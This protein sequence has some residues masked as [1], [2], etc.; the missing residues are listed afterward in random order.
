MGAR[1]VIFALALLSIAVSASARPPLQCDSSY[2]EVW[3]GQIARK[4]LRCCVL[5]RRADAEPPSGVIDGGSLLS[6]ECELDRRRLRR[7]LIVTHNGVGGLYRARVAH[8]AG[9]TWFRPVWRTRRLVNVLPAYG[10]PLAGWVYYPTGHDAQGHAT[11]VTRTLVLVP[12]LAGCA[13][14]VPLLPA[15]C[16]IAP[17]GHGCCSPPPTTTTTLPEHCSRCPTARCKADGITCEECTP[18]IDVVFE[19]QQIT[20]H[21]RNQCCTRWPPQPYPLPIDCT[22]LDASELA[23]LCG[24]YLPPE[25]GC[26]VQP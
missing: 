10:G 2:S 14:I 16:T 3:V 12:Q 17:P 26:C 18:N 8:A 23:V 19:C 25:H 21:F 24:S 13:S 6:A 11:G 22:T 15:F 1:R 9:A 7:Y 20:P 4:A 5:D